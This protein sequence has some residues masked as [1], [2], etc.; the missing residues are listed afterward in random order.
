MIKGRIL[1]LLLFF[2][3]ISIL[4]YLPKC[5]LKRFFYFVQ[6]SSIALL[7]AQICAI[8]N[9]EEIFFASREGR[10]RCR[11]SATTGGIGLAR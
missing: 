7:S 9:R 10:C 5:H 4:F 8:S 6:Q 3:K 1:D 2:Q 11:R